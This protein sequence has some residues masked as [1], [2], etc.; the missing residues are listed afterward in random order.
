MVQ[1]K[2]SQKSLALGQQCDEYLA[3]ILLGPASSHQTR[4]FETINQLNRTVMLQ[5][6]LLGK[7][8]DGGT[9][10]RWQ[11]LD[12]EEKLVLLRLET[13]VARGHFAKMQKTPDLVS[14]LG[15]G[16]VI[17]RLDGLHIYIVTR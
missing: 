3:A 13:G 5:L 12:G 7:G 11:S 15:Q 6:H 2:G 4:A 1:G 8:A 9:E 16:A 17:K 14:E 10:V